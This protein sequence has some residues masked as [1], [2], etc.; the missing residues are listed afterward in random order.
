MLRSAGAV[1]AGYLVFASSAVL[2]FQLSGRQPHASATP[3]FEVVTVI[4]G[5]VFALIA[6]WLT[7]RIAVRRPTTHAAVLAALIALGALISLL[8]SPGGAIWT[9]V[10]A[11]LLMAPAALAG[12]AIARAARSRARANDE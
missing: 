10:A 2:L 11:L 3:A 9:Q 1:A 5:I 6:G 7:A 8:T 4:W 12:G